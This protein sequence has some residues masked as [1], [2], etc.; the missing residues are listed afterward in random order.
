MVEDLPH[1]GLISSPEKSTRPDISFGL[2]SGNYKLTN[3]E[4]RGKG[5]VKFKALKTEG[6]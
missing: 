6:I 1:P 2:S 3:E 4:I 5:L